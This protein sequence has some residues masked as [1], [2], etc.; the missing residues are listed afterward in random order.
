MAKLN[1]K[2]SLPAVANILT[3]NGLDPEAIIAPPLDPRESMGLRLVGSRMHGLSG[4]DNVVT[5]GEVAWHGMGRNVM[6]AEDGK[7][8]MKLGQIDWTTDQLP[9]W[10]ALPLVEGAEMLETIEVPSHVVNVRSDNKA[11]LGVVGKGYKPFHNAQLVD[12]ANA[13]A[14]DGKADIETV[15]TIQGGKRVWVLVRSG[16]FAITP[17]DVTATY[18]ML[19]AGH[20]GS[21]AINAFWTSVRT[22]CQNTFRRAFAGRKNGW[23]IR[24]EGGVME[25]VNAAKAALG[26]MH[27]TTV[28]EAAEALA[29]NAK[30]MNREEL[31]RFWLDVYS[32][33]EGPI[34]Q[35]PKTE[36]ETDAKE[37]GLKVL[38]SWADLF[39]ADRK[40]SGGA[41]SAWT[42]FNAVTEH[43]DHFRPVKGKNDA[44]RADNRLY[45]AL[46]GA[47]AEK[48]SAARQMALALL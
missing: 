25:K 34:V 23:T 30:V 19:A 43:Y 42:A 9:L 28:E 26:L 20:D 45:G 27:A 15:G 35:N 18:L 22:A 44:A 1:L 5:K 32:A 33:N 36:A 39:D 13:L 10:G 4:S 41:A 21:M 12:L 17:Q 29:L 40:R 47:S 16:S 24:H 46:W 14:A 2:S 37:R 38:A 7:E 8:M 6:G 31:Q 11:V 3:T 48:K